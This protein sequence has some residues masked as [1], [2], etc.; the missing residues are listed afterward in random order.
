MDGHVLREN[1]NAIFL[2]SEP[3]GFDGGTVLRV[4]MRQ[5][6]GSQHAIGRFRLS[7]SDDPTF[8]VDGGP[9]FAADGEPATN[10]Y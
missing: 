9:T 1:R 6:F 3:F 5:D 2:P 8:A 4:R 7:I 10:V